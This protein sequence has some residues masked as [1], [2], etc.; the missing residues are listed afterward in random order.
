MEQQGELAACWADDSAGDNVLAEGV[1]QAPHTASDS[2]QLRPSWRRSASA[3]RS[4]SM[5]GFCRRSKACAGAAAV[6]IQQPL[7]DG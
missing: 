3:S 1:E 7:L 2:R 6:A 5:L 4:A